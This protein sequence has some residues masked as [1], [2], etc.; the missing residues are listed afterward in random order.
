MAKDIQREVMIFRIEAYKNKCRE[1]GV[2]AK[3]LQET[4]SMPVDM[5]KLNALRSE[6][7]MKNHRVQQ[8]VSYSHYA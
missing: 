4:K 3:N 5:G 6:I 7:F 1:N 2:S 8:N